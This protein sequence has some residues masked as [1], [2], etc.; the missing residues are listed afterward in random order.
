MCI[1]KLIKKITAYTLTVSMLI[2]MEIP[3]AGQDDSVSEGAVQAQKMPYGDLMP[4][5]GEVKALVFMVEFPD[6]ANEQAQTAEKRK[7]ELFNIKDADS[8]SGFYY[9]S[10]YG[11]LKLDGDVYG[12]YTAQNN[13]TYY[14]EAGY[15]A[16]RQLLLNELL[17]FYDEQIDYSDY[18][19]D[20]DGLVD[21]LYIEYAH[22]TSDWGSFWW[23]YKCPWIDNEG[24]EQ[25]CLDGVSVSNYVWLSSMASEEYNLNDTYK[26]ETGH[27]LGLADYYDVLEG[28][29]DGA[30]GT[31]DMMTTNRGDH[32]AFSKMLLGWLEPIEI[33]EETDIRLRSSQLYPDAA[34]LYPNGDKSS[35]E[36]FMIEYI[37]ADGANSKQENILGDGG[38]R[39]WR[40]NAKLNE[41]GTDYAYY[42]TCEGKK[43]LEAVGICNYSIANDSDGDLRNIEGLYNRAN[44][45]FE[46][47]ELS[48]Y[49]TPSSYIYGE[50]ED[51]FGPFE[52][53]GI[54]MNEIRID[55]TT[56]S[57]SISYD[58]EKPTSFDY[59]MEYVFG[60]MLMI[61]LTFDYET[62]LL[63]ADKIKVFNGE[64]EI[65]L[66]SELKHTP[67]Y[68]FKK[69]Y[70]FSESEK[71]TETGDFTL[72]IEEGALQNVFGVTNNE[73]NETLTSTYFE[74]E[75]IKEYSTSTDKV[76]YA[77]TDLITLGS[78]AYTVY[79]SEGSLYLGRFYENAAGD[80]VTED[81]ELMPCGEKDY[82]NTQ[83]MDDKMLLEIY[84]YPE[85]VDGVSTG[86]DKLY[87]YQL[88]TTGDY[89][90]IYEGGDFSYFP[91]VYALGNN[92]LLD[93]FNSNVV[94]LI[95]SETGEVKEFEAKSISYP[96][97]EVWNIGE[98][99]YLVKYDGQLVVTD[100][101][102]NIVKVI[103]TDSFNMGSDEKYIDF[104]ECGENIGAL[105][106]SN[107]GT[108]E[109]VMIITLDRE[110]NFV[111]KEKILNDSVFGMSSYSA[112][113]GTVDKMEGGYIVHLESCSNHMLRYYSKIV[114]EKTKEGDVWCNVMFNTIILDEEFNYVKSI[115]SWRS[116]TFANVGSQLMWSYGYGERYY[117]TEN[118]DMTGKELDITEL[119][120]NRDT[121]Y[122][123]IGDSYQLREMYEPYYATTEITWES[124]NE[125]V[126]TVDENGYVT[127]VGCG[128]AV[129][130]VTAS[131]GEGL[132]AQCTIIVK[133]YEA[134]FKYGDAN[135]DGIINSQ[136]AVIIQ[137]IVEGYTDIEYDEMACDLDCDGDITEA[138]V[139]LLLEFLAGCE[140]TL[141]EKQE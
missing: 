99:Q 42:N 39:V 20:G 1:K 29:S 86:G 141:G 45:Y 12:Y 61:E 68:G 22:K 103:N 34:I 65:E 58:S 85:Y 74:S 132:E 109:D 7:E 91:K 35:D 134:D 77:Y 2:N 44:I 89:T 63:D 56:A 94:K 125:D 121:V 116:Y 114:S 119:E 110:F 46:G 40:V 126:V 55:G 67:D 102:F 95:I 36:Y 118:F 59:K 17:E 66:V 122:L 117:K 31:F 25:V 133:E 71:L 73:I 10:S 60:D 140:V 79:K 69:M 27:L 87:L 130:T 24:V 51:Y 26:H 112:A 113:A 84:K 41:S 57:A 82:V 90:L 11:Q 139:K 37:T 32:N 53:S 128:E 137:S 64:K 9:T 38:I 21:A 18:D 107:N 88:E 120:V 70:I 8:F 33:S 48:P 97:T 14:E 47:D 80:I 16:G 100:E 52:S 78:D 138:D 104:F 49:S 92:C 54:T 72:T 75:M 28:V 101:E 23:S 131:K 5:K 111:S 3:V 43:L 30:L 13:S 83:L 129:I 105:T 6:V 62:T 106:V 108:D 4:S 15:Y 135:R 19:A 136:D 50:S 98:E 124:Q 115:G 76:N 123:K 81:I 93:E 96:I 127:A